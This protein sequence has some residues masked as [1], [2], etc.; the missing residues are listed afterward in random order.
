MT[1]KERTVI[2]LATE[3]VNQTQLIAGSLSDTWRFPVPVNKDLFETALVNLCY[4][5]AE[6]HG[7]KHT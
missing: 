3:M 7:A 6:L 5:V 1:A 2:T 4:A